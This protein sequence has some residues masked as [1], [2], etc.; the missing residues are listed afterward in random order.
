MCRACV[1]IGVD[2]GLLFRRGDLLDPGMFRSQH[3]EGHAIDGVGA[4]GEDRDLFAL[5]VDLGGEANLRA[6]AA[7]DPV[8]LHGDGLFGPVEICEKSSSSSA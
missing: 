7:P 1:D 3:K 6:F 5:A 4:R 2:F 8:A